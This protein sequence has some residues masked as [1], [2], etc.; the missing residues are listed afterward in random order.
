[1]INLETMSVAELQELQKQLTKA[2]AAAEVRQRNDA[3]AAADEVARNHGFAS[4]RE[5]LG[6]GNDTPTLPK[7]INPSDP[8]MTWTG[9][10]RKPLWIEEALSQGKTMDELRSIWYRTPEE[11][12][13]AEPVRAKP[14]RKS[15]K[16]KPDQIDES[17][18]E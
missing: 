1:M 4:L 3:I 15:S 8:T 12:T 2:L 10:G 9:R 7:Y 16:A 5:L 13:E 11:Q 6:T 14:N 17:S 18:A